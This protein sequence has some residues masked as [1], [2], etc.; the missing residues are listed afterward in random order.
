M[1]FAKSL[2]YQLAL[3]TMKKVQ[4][5]VGC[6]GLKQCP[7]EQCQ[8]LRHW[9]FSEFG[10]IYTTFPSV[11]QK[12]M[13]INTVGYFS[14]SIWHTWDTDP[15]NTGFSKRKAYFS[16]NWL[17]TVPW[18]G[19]ANAEHTAV[20]TLRLLLFDSGLFHLEVPLGFPLLH[21]NLLAQELH[22]SLLLLHPPPGRRPV[23]QATGS[24]STAQRRQ[25]RDT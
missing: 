2:I 20:L 14:D 4:C 21:L 11:S 6:K 1:G 10:S 22:I 25:Q 15:T 3:I 12:S 18:R 17:T 5:P 13:F 19:W 8:T 23:A 9:S 24:L 16:V 7:M